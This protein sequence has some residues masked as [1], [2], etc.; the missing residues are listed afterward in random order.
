[1]FFAIADLHVINHMYYFSLSF[2]IA[3]FKKALLAP[4]RS[5]DVNT[6]LV[7][8]NQNLVQVMLLLLSFMLQQQ[9]L[10]E[11]AQIV[12]YIELRM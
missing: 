5:V 8:L 6:R 9:D 3:L 4:S 7:E 2:L 10:K 12:A 11:K 1:M